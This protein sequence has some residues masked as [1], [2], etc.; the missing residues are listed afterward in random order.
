MD[1]PQ[2]MGVK[3]EQLQDGRCDLRG[4]YRR[5]DR[6]AARRARPCQENGHVPVLS[7]IPAMLGDLAL[8]PGVDDSILGDSDHIG[9]SRIAALDADESRRGGASVYL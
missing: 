1:S 4:L 6:R 5:G 8:V 3:A 9:D 7:V 2:F